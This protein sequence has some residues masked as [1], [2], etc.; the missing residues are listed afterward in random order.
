[1][2]DEETEGRDLLGLVASDKSEPQCLGQRAGE[3]AVCGFVEVTGGGS[4]E[5][6]GWF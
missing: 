6:K 2:Q 1:M 3:G 4:T 5:F